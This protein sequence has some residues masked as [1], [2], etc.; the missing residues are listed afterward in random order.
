[1]RTWLSGL[2]VAAGLLLTVGAVWL[3]FG[4]LATWLGGA[5]LQALSPKDR[6]DALSTIRDQIGTVVGALS[7]G[8]GLYYTARKYFLDRDKQFTDRYKDANGHLESADQVVRAGGVRTLDRILHDSPRDRN[9]VLSSLADFLRAHANGD[10]QPAVTA[11]VDALR[12]RPRAR[13]DEPLNLREI[14][15]PRADLRAI[16][17][18]QA[19]LT[20]AELTGAVLTGATL[21]HA[22]LADATLIGA[23]LTGARLTGAVLTGAR[24]HQADLTGADL[25]EVTGLTGDQ[26]A[27][28]VVDATTAL[29]ENLRES[30]FREAQREV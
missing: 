20:G 21:D 30:H 7:V 25:R 1:M 19:D 6:L 15:L 13:A 23:D 2:A 9:R 18:R 3:L 22:Q 4:P 14:R 5:D 26:L 17:L 28:A 11:A 10:P 24:L 16:D 8:G 12:N 27:R 29:P